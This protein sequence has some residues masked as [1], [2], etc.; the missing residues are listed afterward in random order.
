MHPTKVVYGGGGAVKSGK[1]FL[2]QDVGTQI[3]TY[4]E[5]HTIL[6][7]VEAIMNSRPLRAT[8]DGKVVTTAHFLIG[9]HLLDVPLRSDANELSMNKRLKL[10]RQIVDSF[11]TIWCRDYINTLHGCSK[12]NQKSHNVVENDVVLIG[13]DQTDSLVWPMAKP[14]NVDR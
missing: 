11:W 13:D 14:S 7:Q 3:L 5:L 6:C 9:D 8:R 4:E 12:W 10:T 2:R 1:S